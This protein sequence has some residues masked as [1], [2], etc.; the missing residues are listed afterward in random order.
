MRLRS[1]LLVALFSLS[2]PAFAKGG[3]KT[4][5][6]TAP[7]KKVAPPNAEHKKALLDLMAGF[8]F[9]MTKDEV[10]AT[11]QKKIDETYEEKIKATSDITAQDRLRKEKKTELARVSSTFVS[12]EGK[13]TGWDVSIIENEFAHNTG[14]S[15]MERW[16]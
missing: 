5:A 16:E 6:K 15:M 3:S 10:L 14:E 12:F 11:L 13:R 2:T 8:K 1:A 4:A 9:G 7:K